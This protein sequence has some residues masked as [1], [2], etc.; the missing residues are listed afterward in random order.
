MTHKPSQMSRVIAASRSFR[1][2][3]QTDLLGPNVVDGGKPI[4]R[5]AARIQDA[6]AR[7][8]VFENIGW[9]SHTKVYR[10]IHEPDVDVGR[11]ADSV[12]GRNGTSSA[13]GERVSASSS[14]DVESNPRGASGQQD[15]SRVALSTE[16]LFEPE[17]P[18]SSHYDA[19]KA[20]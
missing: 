20:A 15:T 11:R 12:A 14:T 16:R 4:T 2:V 1:G 6:E 18:S 19:E 8:Y 13:V 9:R 5:L 3:C 7:G 10:L 17:P